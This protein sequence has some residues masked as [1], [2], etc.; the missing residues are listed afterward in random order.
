MVDFNLIIKDHI[1]GLTTKL[2]SS[3][4]HGMRTLG[5]VLIP[6]KN[7][8]SQSH[9]KNSFGKWWNYFVFPSSPK[10]TLLKKKIK[11]PNPS[12]PFLKTSLP[13]YNTFN[14]IELSTHYTH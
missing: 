12:S 1:H 13:T 6:K 14:L 3:N 9:S 5:L 11:I 10:K 8:L 4:E 7:H 2:W